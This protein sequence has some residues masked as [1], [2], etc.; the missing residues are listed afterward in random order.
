MP[1]ARSSLAVLLF[2]MALLAAGCGGRPRPLLPSAPLRTATL[3]QLLAR[4]NR[5]TAAVH[6]LSLK[7]QLTARAGKHKYPRISAFLL[8]RKPAS[9]RLWGTFT[10]LG[11][12]FDMAS[13]GER[14]E[15]EL[16]TR[17]QFIEGRNDVVPATAKS[18]WEKLRP[19]VILNA[20]LINPVPDSQSVALDPNSS[21][22]EYDVFVLQPGPGGFE[23]L[24]RRITFSRYDL[25]PVRQVIYDP[26]GVH[27]TIATYAKYAERGGIPIPTDMT[28]TRPVEGY[29]LRFQLDSKG[30]AVNVPFLQPHTFTLT[31]P[32]G[33]TIIK[34]SDP[35]AG[36]A[37][38]GSATH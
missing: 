3:P 32:R 23:R 30:I 22:S 34:L 38:S 33:S 36:S 24:V 5:D 2:A 12:I 4:F 25:L 9:I 21:P 13:N 26:D 19:Q 20:L 27:T 8:T 18:P 29:T 11:R 16:P 1:S 37:A 7:L 17:N 28:I 31:P 14:F 15:L 10:L 6:T 35:P